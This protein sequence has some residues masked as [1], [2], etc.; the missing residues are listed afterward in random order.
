M[1]CDAGSST[2]PPDPALVAQ[3]IKSMGVQDEAIQKIMANND[4][5]APLQKEEMQFGLDSSRTAYNQSQDDRKY[6]L[7]KRDELSGQQDKVVADANNFNADG[8]QEE[9]AQ[10]AGEDVN[11]AF[12]KVREQ[13]ARTL[14][15]KGISA[16][17]GA[18]LAMGN[19]TDIAQA[20]GAAG[21][22]NATRVAARTEGRGLTDRATNALAGY[23]SMGTST[24][25]AGAGF[26]ASGLTI[27]NTGAAGIN[28]G[29]T[30]AGTMA[31]QLGA[32]ATG[33]YGAQANY[34]SQQDQIASNNDPLK[35]I[36]G[37]AAG[38]GMKKL[39][40]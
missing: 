30:A 12:G 22:T 39:M 37:A 32:N 27:A 17:S 16:N 9:L 26:G 2:P 29:L 40:G 14:A 24:T 5:M 21:A 8:R 31:G 7:G 34:K 6:A 25:G 35:T 18:A 33:M 36:L 1:C 4:A 19:Q 28:S 13:G 15:G 11:Q 38:F 3:Q 10:Q 20:M 23:P